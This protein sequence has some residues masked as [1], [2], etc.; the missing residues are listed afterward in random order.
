MKLRNSFQV[1]INSP[2]DL[3]S[4]LNRARIVLSSCQDAAN[5]TALAAKGWVGADT[6][7]L[8]DAIGALDT[9][10]DTQEGAKTEKS[11]STDARNTAA[12]SLYE[13]LLTI[14]NAANNQWPERVSAN[15]AVRAEFR[16]GLFPPRERKVTPAP[17]PTPS[18]TPTPTT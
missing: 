10:D 2:G 12:N 1:G 5:A 14:Q 15:A 6:T 7:A 11:V 4:V 3:A 13:G 8:S 16:L 17:A 9:T 18:P